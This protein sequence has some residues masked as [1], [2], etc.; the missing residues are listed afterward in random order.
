MPPYLGD[1]ARKGPDRS[2][3]AWCSSRDDRC[4]DG[5]RQADRSRHRCAAGERPA[6]AWI[7]P[8]RA[9]TVA[10]S[11][12]RH[13]QRSG[14]RALRG[15][16]ASDRKEIGAKRRRMRASRTRITSERGR[17]T[18]E[19]TRIASARTR[20]VAPR[21]RSHRR[22]LG[23]PIPGPGSRRTAPESGGLDAVTHVTGMDRSA[24]GASWALGPHEAECAGRG[25]D[26][27]VIDG[28]AA[29]I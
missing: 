5:S 13:H 9:E 29:R 22:A 6:D 27:G 15:R 25:G 8:K 23:S 2:W 20:I 16:C 11:S 24:L 28:G 18:S 26:P 19:R 12:R 14:C 7:R 4:D 21:R 10:P 3:V 1:P 17:I